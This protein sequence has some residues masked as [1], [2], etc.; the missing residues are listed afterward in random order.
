MFITK[1]YI[2]I[3]YKPSVPFESKMVDKTILQL[4]TRFQ[5][6]PDHR[7]SN[8]RYALDDLLMTGFAMF[9][10][11][12]PSLRQYR[13]QF[14]MREANLRRIFGITCLPG[15]TALREGLDG[16]DPQ[17]LHSGFE[18]I[19]NV[20]SEHEV[21]PEREVLGGYVAIS[22]DATGHYCST[23]K[24]CPHCLERK[25]RNGQTS[26]QHQMLA[27]VNVCPGQ[28]TVFPLAC[29]AI[30]KQDGAK[31]NDC[32]LNAARRLIPRLAQVLAQ[33]KVVCVFDALYA[34]GPHIQMLSEHDMR[35]IIV[36]KGQNFVRIQ[37]DRE[38]QLLQHLSWRKGQRE[39]R[40][41]FACD[42]ML[43]GA[44][45]HIRTNYVT[46]VETDLATGKQLYCG[47]WITDLPLEAGMIKEFVAVARARWKIENETFNTLKNQGYHFGHNYGHGKKYLA[48]NFAILTLLAFAVDQIAQHLD[49]EFQQARQVF[50]SRKLLWERIKGVFY[51][52]PAMSMSAIYR[53]LAKR[54]PL[55]IPALE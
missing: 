11:K 21:W 2:W 39:C 13:E 33:H 55:S 10:L 4:R 40:A 15:D 23:S 32:E 37:L 52:V 31:K 25:H 9:F 41:S 18:E 3:K 48:T 26:Y 17:H 51:E 35:Y 8:N 5:T 12:D 45:Q 28:S 27:A 16:I 29:E 50:G 7:R 30:V 14:P 20:L 6:I 36:V 49:T 54:K 44:H 22:V 43:N 38:P 47:S 53:F 24:S 1:N 42:L 46:Y 34:N 19:H